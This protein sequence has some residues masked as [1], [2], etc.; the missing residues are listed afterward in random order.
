[1]YG[2]TGS[3]FQAPKQLKLGLTVSNFIINCV[4]IRELTF[5]STSLVAVPCSD[6][7][8]ANSQYLPAVVLQLCYVQG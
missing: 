6:T 7:A 5:I 2:T 8:D 3:L 1:M 4:I